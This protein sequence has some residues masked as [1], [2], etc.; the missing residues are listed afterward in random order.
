MYLETPVSRTANYNFAVHV[1]RNSSFESREIQFRGTCTSK[2]QFR[3]PRNTISRYMY[4]ETPV[5][6][7]A[8]YNF[9]VHVP[10]NSSFEDREIQFR[11]TCTSKLRFRGPRTTISRYI[12]AA[13]LILLVGKM[14]RWLRLSVCLVV[15]HRSGQI[16]PDHLRKFGL[17]ITVA[18]DIR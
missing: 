16:L 15:C 1:P 4:L 5:S 7:A 3:E 9:A 12:A 13:P 10:R 8:K 11:G 17:M 18:Y 2:L 6:R 14:A